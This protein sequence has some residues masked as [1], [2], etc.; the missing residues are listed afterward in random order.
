MD[1]FVGS[2]I[3]CGHDQ[4]AHT[5]EAKDIR[6]PLRHAVMEVISMAAARDRLLFPSDACTSDSVAE[7]GSATKKA[8]MDMVTIL[9]SHILFFY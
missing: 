5:A 1:P 7:L 8:R 3:A 4:C 2:V 9:V 6:H